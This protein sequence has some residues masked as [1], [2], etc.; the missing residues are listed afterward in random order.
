MREKIYIY[1]IVQGVGFRPFI[2]NVCKKL[3]ILGYV[4]NTASAVYIDAQGS[5]DSLKRLLE[6]IKNNSP[7]LSVIDHIEIY[8]CEEKDYVDFKILESTDDG[9]FIPVSPDMGI[10]DECLKELFD[11]HDRR[12]R[13]PFINCTNCGPRYSIIKNIPYDRPMT[14]MEKFKMCS[15]CQV[16]YD[17]PHNRRFHAQPNGCADCGPHIFWRDGENVQSEGEDALREAI[18][19]LNKGRIVAIKGVGG[20]NLAVDATDEKA[21]ER[22]RKKKHR[23]DKPLAIMVENIDV[24]Q[25]IA[26]ISEEEK[27]ILLSQRRPIVLLKKKFPAEL[28]IAPSVAPDIDTIGIML[29]PTPLHH[30]IARDFGKP[31]VM[32]SGNLSEEPIAKDNDEAIK[33][34]GDIADGFLLHNRD[35]FAR[36]DDSVS[37]VIDGKE[38]LVRRARGY[39]PQPVIY[40]NKGIQRPRKGLQVLALGPHDKVTICIAK[41]DYFFMSQH[42]GDMDNA[43]TLEYFKETVERYKTLFRIYP[44]IVAYDMHPG[45]ITTQYALKMEELKKIAVQH[46]HAHIVS[47]MIDNGVFKKVIGVAYDG[48]G[49]GDDGR[50]WGGEIMVADLYGYQR[51]YHLKYIPLIGGHTAIRKIYKVGLSYMFESGRHFDMFEK[52]IDGKEI[53]LLRSQWERKINV[54]EVSSVGRLFDAVAAVI[55]LRNYTSYEGQA[56]IQLESLIDLNVNG[57]YEYEISEDGIIDPSNIVL[58]AYKDR[59]MGVDLSVIATKFHNSII[60]FTVDA[61]KKTKEFS[62][63]NDVVLTGGVFQNRYLLKNIKNRLEK[64]GFHVYVHRKIPCNDGGISLGQA[65]IALYSK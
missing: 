22:L 47:C 2:Y 56:A 33:R 31:L 40:F 39:A 18:E 30:L 61:V 45:Y 19:F 44:D 23:S 34:L 15:R 11:P 64:E 58:S 13:Y 21:V 59:E 35:I 43:K 37:M 12:Y 52:H 1:G 41:N 49:Y 24:A 6:E 57:Y 28:L 60:M 7:S 46:H 10:C 20:F 38:M 4:K 36:I 25:K 14:T 5:S 29:P 8:P 65:A 9:G 26:L 42:I 63:I 62:D 27:A 32:T 50:L 55:G 3:N 53:G 17:D 16:E 48:T 51:L 54:P